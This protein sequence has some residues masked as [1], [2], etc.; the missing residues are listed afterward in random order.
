MLDRRPAGVESDTTGAV[1]SAIAACR[2]RQDHALP[3]FHP[4]RHA[5]ASWRRRLTAARTP[6]F[7][8][9]DRVR[10]ASPPPERRETLPPQRPKVVPH[11]GIG[12]SLGPRNRSSLA[13]CRSV[14]RRSVCPEIV[15]R[16]V[17]CACPA[18]A[19]R[20]SPC[21]PRET[22]LA[23]GKLA[24]VDDCLGPVEHPG[25][26]DRVGDQAI[27]AHPRARRARVREL[28]FSDPFTRPSSR[29]CGALQP[30]NRPQKSPVRES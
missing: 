12:G 30:G 7:A 27:A 14:G 5:R 3:T 29:L 4:M 19:T 20:V 25:A 22:R 18:P 28:Y 15:R 8:E 13:T 1:H 23:R 6:A 24:S 11:R 17:S 16:R 10:N 2:S 9:A 21:S 26:H